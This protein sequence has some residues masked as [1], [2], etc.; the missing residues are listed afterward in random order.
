MNPFLG[1]LK[2]SLIT[3]EA[4]ILSIVVVGEATS[5]EGKVVPKSP[6]HEVGALFVVVL[7]HLKL[8]TNFALYPRSIVIELA[9][10]LLTP[11]S[12]FV[13]S[14]PALFLKLQ[15]PEITGDAKSLSANK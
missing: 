14:V 15:V 3:L 5:L 8:P 11:T 1:A 9:F 6:L 10:T 4:A 2:V 12:V 13:T 7:V